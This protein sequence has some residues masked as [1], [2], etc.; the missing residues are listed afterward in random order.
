VATFL[1]DISVVFYIFV[2][3]CGGH[4]RRKCFI[5]VESF[6]SASLL[7]LLYGLSVWFR[8]LHS[9]GISDQSR[10][11][12]CVLLLYGKIRTS[13]A[14]AGRSAAGSDAAA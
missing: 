2:M 12:L 9:S 7:F 10:A 6:P 8:V 5:F 14:G 1:L 3:S 11:G 4:V 13:M